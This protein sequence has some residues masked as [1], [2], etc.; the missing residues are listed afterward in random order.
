MAVFQHVRT[1]HMQSAQGIV[2]DILKHY[3]YAVN[4][5]EMSY[6]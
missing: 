4:D 1:C 5:A 2:I 3:R 6:L